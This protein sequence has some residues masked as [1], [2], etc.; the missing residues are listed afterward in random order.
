MCS[1][2]SVWFIHSPLEG[3]P[4]RGR[5]VLAG[6]PR[7]SCP[8]PLPVRDPVKDDRGVGTRAE[9][10]TRNQARA[11]P[12]AVFFILRPRSVRKVGCHVGKTRRGQPEHTPN[13][14]AGDAG[15]G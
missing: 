7:G 5:C 1:T 14:T 12:S 13:P 10:A 15:E 9:A 6:G 8:F 4:I 11:P 2:V 3:R